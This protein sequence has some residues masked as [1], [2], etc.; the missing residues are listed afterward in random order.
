MTSPAVASILVV[1]A[2]FN[3]EV[4]SRLLAGAVSVLEGRG[5]ALWGNG[6]MEVA[7]AWETLGA[8]ALAAK[9]ESPPD[10]ILV[11]GAIV[12]GETEHHT[13]L[14]QAGL[15]GLALV[16]ARAGIPIGLGILTTATV[17]E[18]RTRAGGAK[19]NKGAEAAAALLDLLEAGP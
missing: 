19:G 13:H 12:Q 14:A 17:A 11:L 18:A 7:G 6:P 2:L 4:T 10:G 5:A 3:R 9:A 1:R 8:A 16:Q 15:T